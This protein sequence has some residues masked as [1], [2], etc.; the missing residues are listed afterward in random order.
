MPTS[1]SKSIP[2]TPRPE[3]PESGAFV[4]TALSVADIELANSAEGAQA[5]DGGDCLFMD[6]TVDV[7]ADSLRK[8]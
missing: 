8:A 2:A 4:E 5:D 3:T 1:T 6:K 7:R